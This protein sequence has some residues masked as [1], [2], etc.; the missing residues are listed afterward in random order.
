MGLRIISSVTEE[1]TW[2]LL[3]INELHKSTKT[4]RKRQDHV[5][6]KGEHSSTWEKPLFKTWK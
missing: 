2:V 1:Q 6:A 3:W 4:G 5:Y